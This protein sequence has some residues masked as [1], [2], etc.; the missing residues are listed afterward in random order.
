MKSTGVSSSP[1]LLRE[2]DAA[3]LLSICPRTLWGLRQSGEIPCVRIGRAVRYADEDLRA[4]IDR[5]RSLPDP[6]MN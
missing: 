2:A 3:K 1:L 4:W 6:S 5:N